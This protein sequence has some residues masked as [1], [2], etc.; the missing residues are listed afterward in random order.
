MKRFTTAKITVVSILFLS[1]I[2]LLETV[3][4]FAASSNGSP[5]G[6]PPPQGPPASD[7]GA[8]VGNTGTATSSISGPPPS[9]AR[10]PG[11]AGGP[12]SQGTASPGGLDTFFSKLWKFLY[13]FDS[14]AK[15]SGVRDSSKNLRVLWTRA[16]LSNLGSIEDPIAYDLLPKGTR[17]I[18]GRIAAGTIWKSSFG[19][20]AV[21][22]LDW[23]VQR[24]N[25][26]DRQL[27][28]FLEETEG[29]PSRQVI[30]LGAGYDTRSLRFQKEGVKFFEIDLPDIS[31][32]KENMVRN[33]LAQ[34]KNLNLLP[35]YVGFDLNKISTDG[36]SLV[37]ELLE[38]GLNVDT[39]IPTMVI[40]EAVLFYLMPDAAQGLTKELFALPNARQF[41]FTDNLA[42]V[43]VSP[44][45]PIPPPKAKCENWLR[46]E[47]KELVDH[48][49]IWGGAIHFV[50]AK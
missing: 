6:I 16:L 42:K 43:G 36:K 19:K 14:S 8:P 37:D 50:A 25:F 46:N 33:Y 26:I 24:T 34:E 5:G 45:P 2:T 15:Q 44:G 3:Q 47:G 48:D 9:T 1:F 17:N 41:C 29:S 22:K 40:C 13:L 20:K 32:A 27:K 4:G 23:I 49:S 38:R 12:P 7:T 10:Q 21:E 30:L 31:G 28:S 11:E 18:V 35:S 39:S